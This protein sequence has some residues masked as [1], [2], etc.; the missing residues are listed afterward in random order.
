MIFLSILSL[1]LHGVFLIQFYLT[2]TSAQEAPS[3]VCLKDDFDWDV[4]RFPSFCMEEILSMCRS[5]PAIV[6]TG[7]L[8]MKQTFVRG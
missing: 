6:S 8:V 4:V 1:L 3:G 5:P 2:L 7:P